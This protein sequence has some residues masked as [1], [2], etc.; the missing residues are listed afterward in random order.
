[1]LARRAS[2]QPF[3]RRLYKGRAGRLEF[4]CAIEHLHDMPNQENIDR[5][6][7]APDYPVPFPVGSWLVPG[8]WAAVVLVALLLALTS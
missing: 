3:M 8:F 1:M 7:H 6:R 4:L 5:A 2:G